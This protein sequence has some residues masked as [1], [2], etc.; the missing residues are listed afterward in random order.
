MPESLDYASLGLVCGIEIH[1]QLDTAAKLF[2]GCPTRLRDVEESDHQFFRRLRPARS[3]LGEIDRAALEEVLVS[4][5]FIY[6]SYDSTCLVE[7]DEEPPSEL[8]PEALEIALIVSKLLSMKIA[9][10]VHTMRKIVIDGSNTSGFQRTAYVASHGS[11]DTSCGKVGMETICLEEEAARI[12]DDRGDEV[13]YSLDRLGIPL[14]EIC[15]SPDVVSPQHAREVAQRLGM[16][17]R[18]TGRVKRGLGT[19]RQDVNVSIRDGARVEIKGVQDLN[20]IET[21]VAVEANRQRLLL[22]IKGELLGR[23]AQV[24]DRLADVTGIFAA[25]GSKVIKSALGKGGVVLAVRLGGFAGL[26]GKEIQPGRRL[27]SEISDRAKR[28]G[29]GGIFHSDE[30]PAYG[31]TKEEVDA[32]RSELGAREGDCVAMVAA[33]RDRAEA[34]MKAVLERAKEALVGVPEETRRALPEGTSEYMRPLPGSARM[35]PET[36]V[37]PVVVT[38]DYVASLKLP[39]LFDQKAVRFEEEYGLNPEFAKLIASSPNYQLFEMA[40]MKLST[41]SLAEEAERHRS[42]VEDAKRDPLAEEAERILGFPDA[43]RNLSLPP[44]LVVRTLE[45]IPRELARE[46]I[47][48]SNLTED[49]YLDALVLVAGGGVAKEGIPQLL[50]TMA[51]RP[52]LSAAEAAEAAGLGGVDQSGVEDLVVG[53]VAEKEAFVRERGE[54][55]LGPLM[56]LAMKELRGKADGALVSSVLKREIDRILAE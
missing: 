7:A 16:V 36:D 56:G 54:A 5:K 40:A 50:E 38:S 31:I 39:E 32:V 15:T 24:F 6:K 47:P 44:A 3:E 41:S 8:N 30:L 51:K 42:F 10:E 55:A 48:I 18:S 19:I 11:I 26:L 13:V 4:R 17:L 1:Q 53:I 45:M 43:V 2:C 34:A 22:E 52:E 35:Y 46:G 49:N 14:V 21:I 33:P 12:I 9:D 37:P 20:L 27:G 29:V 25:T 28:A 23:K